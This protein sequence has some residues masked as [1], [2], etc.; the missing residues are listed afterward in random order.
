[1]PT[2]IDARLR[3][4]A[5][6][7]A[8]AGLAWGVSFY[9]LVRLPFVEAHAVVPVTQAQG[10]AATLLSGLPALP[11]DVTLACSGM[12]L[13][14]L[15]LGAVLAYPARW[16]ARVAGAAAGVLL[17][18]LLNTLRIATLGLAATSPAWFAAL[19]LYV[20]PA[21]LVLAVAGYVLWWMRLS[22]T[23]A[24]SA[25]AP[26]RSMSRHVRFILLLAAASVMFAALAPI[27]LTSARVLAV[28]G[29]V[30]EAAALLLSTA[31]MTASAAGNILTTPRGRFQVTQECIVT[32]LI[33]VYVA[34]V[35]AYAGTW[36]RMAPL[37]VAAIPLFVALGIAR[38]LVIVLPA[39]I[40]GS[41][42]FL[43]H[44]FSQVMV[45]CVLV[46][47]IAWWR[48][49]PDAER[50]GRALAGLAAGAACL[51]VLSAFVSR[52]LPM[53]ALDDSQG[54]LALMP[55]FQLAL[56]AALWIAWRAPAGWRAFGVG[57]AALAL[58]Q[59]AILAAVDTVGL[60][61]G[62]PA[63]RAWALAA[64][65]LVFALVARHHDARA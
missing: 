4:P 13:M 7:F 60:I 29:F 38:L 62:V 31:G 64:P 26:A 39:A 19:H 51:Y 45:A 40:G 42:L 9:G 10:R 57:V 50:W 49:R 8:L 59:A 24:S 1:M 43:I 61:P 28:T 3:S 5:L 16:R 63:V 37:L 46:C 12:D 17:I 54:A 52:M 21:V 27:L 35:M 32:P 34:A 22:E 65:I 25:A 58:S 41:P 14:A 20:W 33:P 44:A 56:A 15:C 11:V 6:R 30:A 53:P 47:G 23:P 36:R 48:S 18:L 2:A 55:P